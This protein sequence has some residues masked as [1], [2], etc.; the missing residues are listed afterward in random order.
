MYSLIVFLLCF[1]QLA[2][3]GGAWMLKA[4]D[5]FYYIV[6]YGGPFYLLQRIFAAEFSVIGGNPLIIM[7]FCYHLFKYALF[8]QAHMID[9]KNFFKTLA[10]V[11]EVI[12]LYLSWK[13]LPQMADAAA[14]A[15]AA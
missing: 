6:A 14:V 1:S 15:P 7:M 2:I 9:Q 5:V 8:F 3:A 4:T 10:I 12:Y 13:Y 11:C